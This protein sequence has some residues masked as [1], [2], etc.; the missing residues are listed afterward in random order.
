MKE[1]EIRKYPVGNDN[2]V[3]LRQKGQLYVDKTELIRQMMQLSDWK[4]A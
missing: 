4:I 2:F 3:S 1:P